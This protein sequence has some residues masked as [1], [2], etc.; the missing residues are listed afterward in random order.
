MKAILKSIDSIDYDLESYTPEEQDFFS[1]LVT[2]CIGPDD[3][4]GSEYFDLKICTPKWLVKHCWVPEIFRHTLIVRKYDLEEITKTIN[5]YIEKCNC[6][7]WW[8]TAQKLSRYFA[9][10]FEDYDPCPVTERRECN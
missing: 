10:E 3:E 1:I 6:D 9:W 7:T 5:E 8:E 2:L 4:I